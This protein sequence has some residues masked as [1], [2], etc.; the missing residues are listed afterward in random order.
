[1]GTKMEFNNDINNILK[2]LRNAAGNKNTTPKKAKEENIENQQ[3]NLLSEENKSAINKNELNPNDEYGGLIKKSD[4]ANEESSQKEVQNQQKSQA[5]S[6]K[7]AESFLNKLLKNVQQAK[8]T[9]NEQSKSIIDNQPTIT[10]DTKNI[11][12]QSVLKKIYTPQ[13]QTT[14][15]AYSAQV[16]SQVTAQPSTAPEDEKK[17]ET[18]LKNE[19]SLNKEVKLET[20]LNQEAVVQQVFDDNNDTQPALETQTDTQLQ[21]ENNVQDADKENVTVTNENEET[22]TPQKTKEDSNQSSAGTSKP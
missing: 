16:N 12:S 6:Q 18:P 9:T 5:A 7:V 4:S 22:D 14:F 2:N 3:K 20:S 17:N 11:P 21:E 19:K 13:Y 8:N 1:M 10:P 15:N